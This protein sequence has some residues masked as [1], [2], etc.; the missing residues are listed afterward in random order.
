MSI[1]VYSPKEMCIVADTFVFHTEDHPNKIRESDFRWDNKIVVTEDNH[2]IY[3]FEEKQVPRIIP[4][5]THFLKR[6]EMGTLGKDEVLEHL[7]GEIFDIGIM[8]KRYFYRINNGRDRITINI[9]NTMYSN[10]HNSF[11]IFHVLELPALE[12]WKVLAKQIEDIPHASVHTTLTNK[13]LTL[14]KQ[15]KKGKAKHPQIQ[16]ET[17]A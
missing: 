10:H 11:Y 2:F 14:I 7:K 13:K 16:G 6:F 5:I 9:K 17:T 15:Q 3:A 8:S 12:V 1:I 4:V